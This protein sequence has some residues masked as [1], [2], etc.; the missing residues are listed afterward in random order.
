M[1]DSHGVYVYLSLYITVCY[2]DYTLTADCKN[3]SSGTEYRGTISHTTNLLTCQDWNKQIPHS[4]TTQT[5]P[6][7]GLMKNYCRNPDNDPEGPW[8]FTDL[9]FK[10]WEHCSIPLCGL[11]IFFLQISKKDHRFYSVSKGFHTKRWGHCIMM[12]SD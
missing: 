1:I 2:F 5:F 8:C 11:Y 4:Y 9:V 12:L 7:A 10:I 3:T 6:N